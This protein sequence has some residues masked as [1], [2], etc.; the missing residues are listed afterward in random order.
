MY[1]H[2]YLDIVHM[3]VLDTHIFANIFNFK[4]REQDII[5]TF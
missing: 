1:E 2:C 3:I 4:L 5:T